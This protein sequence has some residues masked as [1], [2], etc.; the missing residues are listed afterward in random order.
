MVSSFMQLEP[1]SREDLAALR[2]VI[3]ESFGEEDAP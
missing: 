2:R 1:M 3:D